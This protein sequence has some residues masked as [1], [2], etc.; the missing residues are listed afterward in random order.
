MKELVD[1]C[2]ANEVTDLIMIHEHRG[3]PDAMIISHLPHGPTLSLTLNNVTLR[4]DITSQS[5]STVS[6]QYP[7]LIFDNFSTKLGGRIKGILGALFPPPKE[8]AR[9]VMT[10]ANEDD[11]ISFR[12]HVFV[13][14]SHK[15]VQLAEVG[16]RFEA[17]RKSIPIRHTNWSDPFT[18]YEIRLGTVDQT[19]A[20]VEWLLRPYQRTAKKRT[21]L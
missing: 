11:F 6:E 2:R 13:K 3:I 14:N 4:H 21:E 19:E 5:S 20:D 9:R 18:A 1:A 12:H 17:K 10:F 8:D 15:D 16:P 7:H